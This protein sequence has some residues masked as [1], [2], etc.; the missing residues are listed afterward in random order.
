MSAS[1]NVFT[2]CDDSYTATGKLLDGS[3]TNCYS[4]AD[5]QISTCSCTC[6]GGNSCANHELLIDEGY[7][8]TD[9]MTDALSIKRASV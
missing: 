3:Q 8:P 2:S 5:E 9:I 6:L 7:H 1:N 4:D